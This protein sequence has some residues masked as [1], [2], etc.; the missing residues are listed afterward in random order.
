MTSNRI[1]SNS[2]ISFNAQFIFKNSNCF[3]KMPFSICFVQ[4]RSQRPPL[5]LVCLLI[6][7]KLTQTRPSPI[8]VFVLLDR[9]GQFLFTTPHLLYLSPSMRFHVSACAYIVLPGMILFSSFPTNCSLVIYYTSSKPQLSPL[10]G[11][12]LDLSQQI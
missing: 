7:F 1:Y 11:S 4:N 12:L 10:S 5:H 8:F 9:P 3:Q 2:L 6:L